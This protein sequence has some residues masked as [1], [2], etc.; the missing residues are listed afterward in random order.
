MEPIR[1]KFTPRATDYTRS[2]LNY[3]MRQPLSKVAVVALALIAALVICA[4]LGSYTS[5][6]VLQPQFLLCL[7]IPGGFFL[8]LITVSVWEIVWRYRRT[9]KMGLA[10]QWEVSDELVRITTEESDS[11]IQ[12]TLFSEVIDTIDHYLFRLKY[13]KYI[14]QIVPKRVFVSDEQEDEFCKLIE[15]H[16]GALK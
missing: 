9:P 1:F 16:I 10:E 4:E 7:L 6:G 12:W 5:D 15:K 11:K 3:S 2:V 14:V 8:L 13:P